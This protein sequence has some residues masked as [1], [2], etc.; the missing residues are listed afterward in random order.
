MAGM[1][2][3]SPCNLPVSTYILFLP[4]M[5]TSQTVCHCPPAPSRLAQ[6]ELLALRPYFG[7]QCRSLSVR[8]N[9]TIA[10]SWASFQLHFNIFLSAISFLNSCN[11]G[12]TSA[13]VFPHHCTQHSLAE[14]ELSISERKNDRNLMQCLLSVTNFVRLNIVFDM[15]WGTLS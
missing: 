10:R 8:S 12:S 14:L 13:R 7:Y 1:V 11:L 9:P 2:L 6:D 4:V 5:L 3:W 15:H